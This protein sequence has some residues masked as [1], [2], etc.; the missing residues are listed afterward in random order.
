MGLVL[1][2][3]VVQ[4]ALAQDNVP[5]IIPQPV[6]YKAATG[7]FSLSNAT[8]M[9]FQGTTMAP[10]GFFKT[11]LR[12]MYGIAVGKQQPKDTIVL[13]R[14]HEFANPSAYRLVITPK[15]IR[16]AASG[17]EGLFYGLQTVLQL[18]P[19]KGG[20][21]NYAIGC[22][23]VVDSPRF[24]YR[25]MHLDVCRHF[26]PVAFVK[27]Y[28]DFLA[29]HKMNYFHWHLTDDQGWRIEIKKYPLLTNVGGCRS[30]TIIGHHPGTGDDG[31]KYCGYY[32][33]DEIRD[34]V[35]YAAQRYITI[36]P[37]IEM[38]GHA[39][40]ALAAYPYLGCPGTGPYEVQ[41]TWGVFDDVFCAGKDSTFTFL[42][43]VIDEVLPLFPSKVI[44]VG[45]DECP[46]ENWKHCPLCQ[47]RIKD[48]H[49][50]DEGELQSYFVQRMEKYLNTKGRTLM[51][52]DEILE[53]GLAPNAMVMSWRGEEGG[54]AAAK[55]GHKVVMTPGDFCYLD[56]SQTEKD[57]SLTIGG[58]TSL[59]KVYG[60]EP[61]PK[62]LNAKEAALIL[63]A[64]GNVWTEYMA[65]PEKVEYMIFPRMTA[66][67][68]VLWSPAK[69]HSWADF[70][71]RMGVQLERYK[72]WG[73]R[74]YPKLEEPVSKK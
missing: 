34:V 4:P 20:K 57:D 50:K 48:N 69:S 28:I 58:Y 40:A 8:L 6:A 46:K 18:L 7:S 72:L 31:I 74:Y 12:S 23:S 37:E 11:Y 26:M 49:L 65:S 16:I 70:K 66:L 67:S 24:A 63:G 68:E 73:V 54:V 64:Q 29:L 61:L 17:D 10:A 60:F 38:P 35:A 53:G 71:K 56:H 36:I 2:V 62:G 41:H 14:V 3:A 52:W 51:G 1:A 9:Q 43:N 21:D 47:K 55:Q 59:E 32:T 27:K 22:A 25:G 45:G 5:A 39:M 30:G 44:H 33:Q 15:K 19:P 42:Q 13:A